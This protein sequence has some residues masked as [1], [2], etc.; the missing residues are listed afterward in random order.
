[1]VV[2]SSY[3]M[4][5]IPLYLNYIN[6]GKHNFWLGDGTSFRTAMQ[7]NH[8]QTQSSKRDDSP[9]QQSGKRD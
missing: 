2:M 4:F 8:T 3:H 5:N 1:M 6:F 7:F 9:K